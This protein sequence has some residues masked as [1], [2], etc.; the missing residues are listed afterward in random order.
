MSKRIKNIED[1]PQWF[2]STNY[3][4]TKLFNLS[5]WYTAFFNRAIVQERLY[6]YNKLEIG[7][8]EELTSSDDYIFEIANSMNAQWVNTI[9]ELMDESRHQ[10][11]LFMDNRNSNKFNPTHKN[12]INSSPLRLC[13]TR[14]LAEFTP[15]ERNKN[16]QEAIN[17]RFH[18]PQ[19]ASFDAE[20]ASIIEKILLIERAKGQTKKEIL[21]IKTEF[22]LHNKK[23]RAL[24]DDTLKLKIGN[25]KN[26][27]NS[28]IVFL[29]IDTLASDIQ[30][31]EDFEHWLMH[32][33]KEST[34]KKTD[35][36]Q[37]KINSWNEYNILKYIDLM[38]W[39]QLFRVK[40][41]KT[42]LSSVLYP[43]EQYVN[44]SRIDTTLPDL[45]EKVLHRDH[46]QRV[47]LRAHI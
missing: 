36:S 40:I 17:K 18:K 41:N 1:L 39:E 29:E 8:N 23:I 12:N 6:F 45:M 9:K 35:I 43:D 10:F 42:F 46:I 24:E 25:F 21:Q 2:F 14:S 31:K 27:I 30:L 34:G 16:E 20:D 3:E 19:T 4:A 47:K 11:D 13:G 33:R 28:G 15:D 37:S 38:Q 32:Y 22:E 26:D 44:P 5:D 7:S